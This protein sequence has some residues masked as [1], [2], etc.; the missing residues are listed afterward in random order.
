MNARKA[1]TLK[2]YGSITPLTSEPMLC[3]SYLPTSKETK[4]FTWLDWFGFF[5][6]CV[7]WLRTYDVRNWLMVSSWPPVVV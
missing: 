5:L 6:P 4:G 3:C 7:A 2:L 1:A